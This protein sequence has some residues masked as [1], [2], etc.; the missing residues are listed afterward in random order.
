MGVV[1][2]SVYNSVAREKGGYQGIEC[3]IWVFQM[4]IK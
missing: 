1:T 2:H 3:K 4:H